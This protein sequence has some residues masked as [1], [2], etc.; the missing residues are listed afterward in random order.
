M[1]SAG[2]IRTPCA[3]TGGRN[4]PAGARPRCCRRCWRRPSSSGRCSGACLS[5]MRGVLAP[6]ATRLKPQLRPWR[7][8]RLQRQ[9]W[10][11]HLRLFAG[12]AAQELGKGRGLLVGEMGTELGRAHHRNG[13][14]Q[15]PD[16][17][18][19]EVGR[20]ERDIAQSPMTKTAAMASISTARVDSRPTATMPAITGWMS[21]LRGIPAVGRRRR[22]KR[23]R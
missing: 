14:L 3:L 12:E 10:I 20:R 4:P 7:C 2:S 16:L 1:D 13:L 17:V 8:R 15:I 19:M 11:F 21:F 9:Q 5:P 23:S 6:P 18:R 22:W